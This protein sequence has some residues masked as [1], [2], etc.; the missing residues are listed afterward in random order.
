MSVADFVS[1][2]IRNKARIVVGI[3]AALVVPPLYSAWAE[4]QAH[5]AL[6]AEREG[7]NTSASLAGM[8]LVSAWRGCVRIGIND[9]AQ[10]STYEGKLIQ[11]MTA[12]PLAKAALQQRDDF[13]GSC[14]KFYT[15]E[16]CVQLLNR[17]VSLSAAGKD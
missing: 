14:R 3:I 2:C 17:S 5:D 8:M 16:Y 9:V 15:Q 10:C 4:R 13:L 11:E 12:P 7:V 1:L 6:V